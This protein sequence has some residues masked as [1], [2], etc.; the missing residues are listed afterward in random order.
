MEL[1]RMRTARDAERLRRLIGA[2]DRFRLWSQG[3]R[4]WLQGRS[5]ARPALQ[6][7]QLEAWARLQAVLVSRQNYANVL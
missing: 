4:E 5:L 6:T 7:C 3:L 2:L 1:A